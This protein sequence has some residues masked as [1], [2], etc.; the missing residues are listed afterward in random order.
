MELGR[1]CDGDISIVLILCANNNRFNILDLAES[2]YYFTN[3]QM[4]EN[5]YKLNIALE[6]RGRPRNTVP[7][8]SWSYIYIVYSLLSLKH[9]KNI[10]FAGKHLQYHSPWTS[11]VFLHVYSTGSLTSFWS[12][13]LKQ[14]QLESGAF[15]RNISYF[16][17]ALVRGHI[18]DHSRISSMHLKCSKKNR[19][20]HE[21]SAANFPSKDINLL[22]VYYSI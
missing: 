20:E 18:K 9:T 7:W 21:T 13:N 2:K 14:H 17:P 22:V 11:L 3:Q 5:M 16:S 4:P 15:G 8:N 19:N 10:S 12:V 6:V 1:L